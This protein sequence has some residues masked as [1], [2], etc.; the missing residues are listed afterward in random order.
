MIYLISTG[1]PHPCIDVTFDETFH[2]CKQILH[3]SDKSDTLILQSQL[4]SQVQ[5]GKKFLF[6]FKIY[7][8]VH[9]QIIT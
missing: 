2:H 5:M 6:I 7:D 3:L 9:I 4:I 1:G 8:Q